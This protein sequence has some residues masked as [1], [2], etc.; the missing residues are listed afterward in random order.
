MAILLKTGG[1]QKSL[2]HF[3]WTNTAINS[4]P[5][6]TDFSGILKPRL[7]SSTNYTSYDPDGLYGPANT[8]LT[9]KNSGRYHIGFGVSNSSTTLNEIGI[10][11]NNI[12]RAHATAPYDDGR[13]QGIS[14][15]EIILSMAA[16]DVVELRE[17]GV[18]TD[19]RNAHLTLAQLSHA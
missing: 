14:H 18:S 13:L 16:G 9:I 1:E 10:Y 3:S 19:L 11:V 4:Y 7:Y 17:M 15:N 8:Q 12:K 6:L 2:H 5:V